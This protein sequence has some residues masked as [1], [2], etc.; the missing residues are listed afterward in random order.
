MEKDDDF[1]KVS[2]EID[3]SHSN[4]DMDK[5]LKNY[6]ASMKKLKCVSFVSLFFIVA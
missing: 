4:G 6:H 2:E 5:D 3:F 1:K